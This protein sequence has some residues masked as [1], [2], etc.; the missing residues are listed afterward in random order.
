MPKVLSS[1]EG[2]ERRREVK[3][4]KIRVGLGNTAGPK[5]EPVKVYLEYEAEATEKETMDECLGT[6]KESLTKEVEQ[7]CYEALLR[8]K[9]EQEAHAFRKDGA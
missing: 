6:I 2:E 9:G 3:I 7:F 8:L 5:F 1:A 4:T